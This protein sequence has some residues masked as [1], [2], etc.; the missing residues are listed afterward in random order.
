MAEHGCGLKIY[1]TESIIHEAMFEILYIFIE[2]HLQQSSTTCGVK[3]C[4]KECF[5]NV[6]FYVKQYNNKKALNQHHLSKL[7]KNNKVLKYSLC[8]STKL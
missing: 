8:I 6:L 7:V 3:T 5:Q 1:Q 2:Y 4:S